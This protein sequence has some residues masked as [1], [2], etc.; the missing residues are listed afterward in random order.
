L[1]LARIDKIKLFSAMILLVVAIPVG[2]G[3]STA[4]EDTLYVSGKAV[5]FFGLSQSE[6]L[7][8][9][10]EQKDAIDEELYDFYHNRGEVSPFLASNAI[11]AISTAR[12]NIQV[13]L[14]GNQS[15]TYFRRDFDRVLGLILT[16]GRQEPLVLLGPAAVSDLIAQFEEYFGINPP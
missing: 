7:A 2:W 8:M 3:Q 10:H 12:L 14:E 1:I 11:E 13:Q 4:V 6:Y 15:I 16:D 9:T 5:V